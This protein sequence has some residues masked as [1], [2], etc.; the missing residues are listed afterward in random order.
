M[1]TTAMLSDIHM[2]L[3]NFKPQDIKTLVQ[4]KGKATEG[5]KEFILKDIPSEDPN[6]QMIINDPNFEI[7]SIGNQTK[8]GEMYYDLKGDGRQVRV[9]VI[10]HK[11]KKD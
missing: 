3:E 2:R 5:D 8:S 6:L 11:L 7:R 1:T 9:R 4:Q 10:C